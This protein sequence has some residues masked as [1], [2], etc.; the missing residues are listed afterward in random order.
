LRRKVREIFF[1][2]F[3]MAHIA[4]TCSVAIRGMPHPRE[5]TR[6]LCV[7]AHVHACIHTQYASWHAFL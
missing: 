6:V 1:R 5:P 2:R 7:L 3:A 4:D